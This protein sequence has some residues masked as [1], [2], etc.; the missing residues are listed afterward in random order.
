M[1]FCSS[2]SFIHYIINLVFEKKT[3]KN[4]NKNKTKIMATIIKLFNEAQNVILLLRI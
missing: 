1:Q 3:K 2:L 4:K